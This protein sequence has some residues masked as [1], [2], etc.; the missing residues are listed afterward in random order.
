V[1]HPQAV[2]GREALGDER[3]VAGLGVA[4]DAQERRQAALR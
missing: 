1:P 2:V 3:S 4:L